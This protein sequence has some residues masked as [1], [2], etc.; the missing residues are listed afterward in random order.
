MTAQRGLRIA[1]TPDSDDAFTYYAWEHGHVS[2]D[3]DGGRPVFHRAHIAEL[4]RAAE[5]ERYD[6]VAVS[7]VAYPRLADRYWILATGNSV[8]RDFGPVLASKRFGALEE[9]R[10]R[11]VG[12]GGHPTTGSVL[13]CFYA[14]PV[15]LV[16]LPYDAIAGAIQ[17]D[18]IAAGVMIHEEIL[19]FQDLGLRTVC[20]LGRAWCGETGLPLP[21]GL[22]L[23]RREL[24]E[25]LARD[26][27]TTCQRSLL[28]ALAHADEAYA[29]ASRFGRGRAREHV[30]MFDSRDTLSL[31]D[32]VRR[33]LGLLFE[34]VA[35][36][37]LGPRV[38]SVGIVDGLAGA[39][40]SAASRT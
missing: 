29:W 26:V 10:G 31:P 27:A 37:G 18:E 32:D 9:L 1:Y 39:P 8:G 34:R 7:A 35:A 33:S 3:A 11:R 36:A 30:A 12:V 15:E 24:G 28:W 40:L 20:D 21:V 19:S 25:E 5:E 13:A 6:V 17:R 22:N 38:D 14:P 2:L 23:V 16:E 4:N